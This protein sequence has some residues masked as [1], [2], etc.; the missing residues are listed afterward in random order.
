VVVRVS[1]SQ[2]L[3]LLNAVRWI[4][5]HAGIDAPEYPQLRM[6]TEVVDSLGLSPPESARNR[7]ADR[8]DE[9]AS[10]RDKS[11]AQ[12][13]RKADDLDTHAILYGEHVDAASAFLAHQTGA[14][15]RTRSAGDRQAAAGDRKA[16]AGDRKAAAAD[17]L[18]SAQ[19]RE[20]GAADNPEDGIVEN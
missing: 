17:Q 15:D 9:R 11:A 4:E 5:Q 14:A 12:G 13:D 8:R 3:V 19:D 6:L 10:A 2:Y 16:A 20:A 1:D 7:A 18:A